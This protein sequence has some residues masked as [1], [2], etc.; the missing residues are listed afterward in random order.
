M[1]GLYGYYNRL[2][3]VVNHSFSVEAREPPLTTTE[4]LLRLKLSASLSIK[5]EGISLESVFVRLFQLMNQYHNLL[6][7]EFQVLQLQD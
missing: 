4:Q 6:Q 2:R 1:A 7:S 3:S 5:V